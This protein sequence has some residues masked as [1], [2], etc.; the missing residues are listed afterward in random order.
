MQRIPSQYSYSPKP[1]LNGP[2]SR[3]TRPLRVVIPEV[4]V[5][6][7][8]SEWWPVS[9]EVDWI[10]APYTDNKPN[11]SVLVGKKALYYA[12]A[13]RRI[14]GTAID[15]WYEYPVSSDD[16][17]RPSKYPFWELDNVIMTPHHS[18]AIIGTR[19]RRAASVTSNIGRLANG[20]PLVNVTDEISTI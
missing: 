4:P 20:E 3:V 7:S 15:I 13:D 11:P 2:T 12:V 16:A 1:K 18:G 8:V 19:A 17:P 9:A 10:A 14:D 6:I 5:G